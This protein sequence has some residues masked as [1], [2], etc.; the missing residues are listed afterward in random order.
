MCIP[1]HHEKLNRKVPNMD[2]GPKKI[3]TTPIFVRQAV[4]SNWAK[5]GKTKFKWLQ[6]N[7][8]HSH[9][10][11]KRRCTTIKWSKSHIENGKHRN[12]TGEHCHPALWCTMSTE[13]NAKPC[14]SHMT[15]DAKTRFSIHLL[16]FFR[17]NFLNVKLLQYGTCLY[18]I[19]T[20]D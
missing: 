12:D 3:A 1:T 13:D 20:L 9:R 5:P 11:R 18:T 7:R 14:L 8:F 15:F 10:P 19:P 6:Q 16:V 17:G 2:L 4:V